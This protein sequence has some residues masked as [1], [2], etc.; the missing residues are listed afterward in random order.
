[1]KKIILIINLC[2][3]PLFAE[4]VKIISD[5]F[6]GNEDKGIAIFTGHVKIT[7]EQDELNASKV[8]VYTDENQSPYRYEAEGDT[9]FYIH[10]KDRNTTYTGDAGKIVYLPLKKE[11]QFYHNVHLYQLGSDRKVFGDEVILNTIDG[12]AKA[13]GKEKAPVIMIFNIEE[14]PDEKEKVKE[15]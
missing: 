15:K 6:E 2:L 3:L 11:Y 7:K 9:S 13:I 14:K 10:L 8:S 4:Q 5:A 1:M 12:N